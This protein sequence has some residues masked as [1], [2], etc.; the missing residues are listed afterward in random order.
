MRLTRRGRIVAHIAAFLALLG[1]WV[2]LVAAA[3]LGQEWK[4]DR[5]RDLDPSAP[6]GIGSP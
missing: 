4:A 5:L 1:L 6:H 2:L 3:V